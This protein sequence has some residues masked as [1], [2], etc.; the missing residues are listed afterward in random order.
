V[1]KR[2]LYDL[3]ASNPVQRFSPYC[4]RIKLALAF[5]ELEF[6]SALVRFTDKSTI[7]FSG[8]K[9]LPILVDEDGTVISDSFS[10][11]EYLEARYPSPALFP[12]SRAELHFFRHWVEKSFHF[13]LFRVAAPHICG[14]LSGEDQA[15]FRTTREARL[16]MPLAEL[17]EQ[18]PVHKKALN[19]SV[20]PLRITLLQQLYFSGESAGLADLLLVSA[21]VWAEMVL[22][23]P[24]LSSDDPLLEW[25]ARLQPWVEAATFA[26][27]R[28]IIK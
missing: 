5:K 4:F 11:L 16:G 13:G 3:A 25:R 24:W 18:A 15:Y 7:A 20:E 8:Q 17:A 28:E 1:S 14:L 2:T 6:C 26:A 21:F 23:E 9:M 19:A 22:P 10:I 12:T 27:A